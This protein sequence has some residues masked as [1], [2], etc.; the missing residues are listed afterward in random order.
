MVDLVSI[1]S[2]I[3]FAIPILLGVGAWA[4]FWLSHEFY[5]EPLYS[6]EEYSR[7]S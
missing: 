3:L 4:G 7:Q 5:A 2:M 6:E 1:L